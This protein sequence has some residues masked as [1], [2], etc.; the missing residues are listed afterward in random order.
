MRY[1]NITHDDMLNGEGLRVVLW[2]SGCE[3]RCEGC[4]NPVTWDVGDGLEFGKEDEKELWHYLEQS[5]TAGVTFSGGDPFHPANQKE[6]GRLIELSKNK[7]P[8]K[9]IWVYTGYDWE[10]VKSLP[11]INLVDVLVDGEFK[12]DL[13]HGNI[14]W[15]G[16]TNQRII[17]VP[18]SLESSSVILWEEP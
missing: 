5:H 3:H 8:D 6:V 12:T 11:F 18:K 4:H 1:H 7:Y 14:H 13:H 9:T 17:D 16:S 2:V 15:C 10:D